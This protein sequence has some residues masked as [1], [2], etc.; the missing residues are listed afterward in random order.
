M[1]LLMQRLHEVRYF[2][3]SPS[4]SCPLELTERACLSLCGPP[5]GWQCNLSLQFICFICPE[6]ILTRRMMQWGQKQ[7]GVQNENS[8]LSGKWQLIFTIKESA[9]LLRPSACN[10]CDEPRQNWRN[11]DQK[12][13]VLAAGC[14]PYALT[15]EHFP[16]PMLSFK[17][18]ISLFLFLCV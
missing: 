7:A 18:N 1:P 9:R 12:Q 6:G 14:Q 13:K 4:N 2:E 11:G 15:P 16:A 17:S 10:C 8:V 3:E 5:W